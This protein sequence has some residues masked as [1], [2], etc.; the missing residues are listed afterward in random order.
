[1]AW[2]SAALASWETTALG[3]DIPLLAAQ[4]IPASPTTV[5]W[6]DSAQVGSGN[7][8][9]WT[10][11]AHASYPVARAYDGYPHL[12]TRTDAT[13]SSTWYYA[14]DLGALTE[15]DCL[16][17]IGTNFG[18][19]ALTTVELQVADDNAFSTNLTTQASV[20]ASD[21]RMID[22]TMVNGRITA[23]YVWLKLSKGS[24]FTPQF[25]E[26]IIG[27]RRQLKNMPIN[28]FDPTSLHDE[29]SRARS[30]GG[31]THSTVFHRR[32]FDLNLSLSTHEDTH[33]NNLISWFQN[34]RNSFVWIWKPNTSPASWHLMARESDDFDFPSSDWSE[35]TTTIVASEQ[36]PE[37]YFL[38]QE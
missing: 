15:F 29:V 9:T 7:I 30:M 16:F 10:N 13:V 35:R 25:G 37:T 8:G 28:P 21:D 33:T 19:L 2:S 20:T 11:R 4:A 34:V 5:K 17:L 22:L 26:M 6:V 3:N 31:V 23:Q 32:R 18:T 1:M 24:S 27:R 14:M 12:D 36:G 38:D